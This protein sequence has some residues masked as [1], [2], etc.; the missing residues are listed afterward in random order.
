MR[1]TRKNLRTSRK[2]GDG[3]WNPNSNWNPT[4][5]AKRPVFLNRNMMLEES[6]RKYLQGNKINL[7]S[8]QKKLISGTNREKEE[9]RD[10]LNKILDYIS[11]LNDLRDDTLEGHLFDLSMY[12]KGKEI[13]LRL[14]A[15]DII[16]R[17]KKLLK[18]TDIETTTINPLMYATPA[19]VV[20]RNGE[21][22]VKLKNN[23][24]NNKNK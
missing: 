18:E 10:D 7:S 14:L 6:K 4:R 1:K 11:L 20:E 5:S 23:N 24:N 21:L 12:E 8:Y 2:G 13:K 16:K 3:N 9:A 22:V 19:N 15:R 17:I